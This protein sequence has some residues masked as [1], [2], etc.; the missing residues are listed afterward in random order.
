MVSAPRGAVMVAGLA[1]LAVIAVTAYVVARSAI[2]TTDKTRSLALA[3]ASAK[4][5][6]TWYAQILNYD[7]YTNRAIAAN[8][9][10]IA[11]SVTLAAWT[12]QV[13]TLSGNLGFVG[14]FIPAIQPMTT[15]I[16]EVAELS[17]QL[18]KT[19]ATL[20]VPIRSGY[21]KALELSQ[22]IMHSSATPFAAQA[23]V[24]EV[25]W[26][27]DKRFFGQII[28]SS[29]ISGFYK[30]TKP[31][32]GADRI[33]LADLISR[34]RDSF[35]TSRSFDK[36]LYLLPTFRCIPRNS[37]QFLSR[38]VKR[39]GTWMTSDFNQ[40]ES[41]DTLS[42]HA[43]A[44]RSRRNPF[45]GSISET[46]SLGW[47]A[48]DADL[49][50]FGGINE[51]KANLSSNPGAFSD[52]RSSVIQIAGYQGLA[53]FRELRADLA[54]NRSQAA[55]RVPVLVRLTESRMGKVSAGSSKMADA[56]TTLLG[57]A[58][59]S[60]A[61]AETFFHRP[62]DT[63]ANPAQREFA[64]LF[65]PFWGS[66]LIEPSLQDKTVATSIAQARGSE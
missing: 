38:L 25:I 42:V 57:G 63:M 3:D 19:G 50:G 41:V 9:I 18:A 4:S 39:G 64:N 27:A 32:E 65:S 60:L 54:A 40:W 56:N 22:K 20:E 36:R 52:A 43:W 29:D 8:E 13:K 34:S 66:R 30:L 6:A 17:H 61:V 15:W 53:N 37:D 14:S 2:L 1:L 26:T 10:M 62:A 33:S 12:H 11:Q 51:D 48:S 31:Y 5:V 49:A 35:S 46:W 55:S 28:P 24:N 23:L 45:C 21:T 16:Q 7:A 59:W 47:G 44:R 58:I